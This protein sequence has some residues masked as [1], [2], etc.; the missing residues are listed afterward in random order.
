MPT[1]AWH[2]ISTVQARVRTSIAAEEATAR[3][4]D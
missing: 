2:D 4:H 3:V 1:Q